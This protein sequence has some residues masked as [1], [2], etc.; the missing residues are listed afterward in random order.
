[1]KPSENNKKPSIIVMFALFITVFIIGKMI[2]TNTAV[3]LPGNN[4]TNL[5][6][7]NSAPDRNLT[8]L[9]LPENGTTNYY[10]NAEALAPFGVKTEIGENY[11][12]KLVDADTNKTAVTVFV[13]GGD[14]INIK[15][16]LGAYEL[17]SA[18]GDDWYGEDHLFGSHTSYSK[19]DKVFN[20]YVDGPVIQ[21]N[22]VELIN[23][24]DGNLHT[25]K[26]D[27]DEF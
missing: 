10:T 21:G 11:F 4:P 27:K 2:T 22:T 17:R 20:F 1:M 8:K 24:V 19:A 16:P 13:R 9:D 14:S 15:V 25:S 6:S 26:I 12:I 5:S 3:N 18:A 7:I 23:R